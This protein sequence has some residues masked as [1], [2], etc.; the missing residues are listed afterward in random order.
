METNWNTS[1]PSSSKIRLKGTPEPI[2][3]VKNPS[4]ITFGPTVP[5]EPTNNIITRPIRTVGATRP[6]KENWLK[7]LM[8]KCLIATV[9]TLSI[10]VLLLIIEVWPGC[11]IS[12][13]LL[14]YALASSIAC[15]VIQSGDVI[16]ELKEEYAGEEKVALLL[17]H[18]VNISLIWEAFWLAAG[19]VCMMFTWWAVLIA[20]FLNLT[21]LLAIIAGIADLDW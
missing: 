15:I 10:A 20:E 21:L 14:V 8:R 11:L 18:I 13:A 5:G 12:A 2:V 17:N 19:L 7:R 16:Y 1:S 9:A 3:P 6:L 4:K